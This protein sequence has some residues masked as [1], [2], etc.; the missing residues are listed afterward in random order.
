MKHLSIITLL[1]FIAFSVPVHAEVK[2]TRY[3]VSTSLFSFDDYAKEGMTGEQN[4]VRFGLVHTR[5]V[6][7]NNSRWRWWLGL[8]YLS[9]HVPAPKA[10]GVYQEVDNIELRFLPQYAYPA[11]SW[12][13]PFVGAG[14]TLGY[15]QFSYRWL[16][17][18][19]GYKYGDQLPDYEQFEF[20]LAF[21]VGT[22]F[23]LGS[24]PNAH[25]QIVPQMFVLL[26]VGDGLSGIEFNV[27]VL[28]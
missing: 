6:D 4:G 26:P 2:G 13:T 19:E 24:N 18:D 21:N 20:S 22:A 16:V 9:D 28:F 25:L 14:V 7:K 11:T 12:M 3:G 8:N 15:S 5:P 23:K 17:D 1:V 27:S 10:G